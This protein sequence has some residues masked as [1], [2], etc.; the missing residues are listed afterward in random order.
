M[1]EIIV[2]TAC[3]KPQ[4]VSRCVEAM[5]KNTSRKDY[6]ISVI[7]DG[8]PNDGTAEWCKKDGKVDYVEVNYHSCTKTRNHGIRRVNADYYVLADDDGYVKTVGWLGKMVE[9]AES[10]PNVLL[11]GVDVVN[12]SAGTSEGFTP[13][14]LRGAPFFGE[15]RQDNRG[16]WGDRTIE[17]SHVSS[18][19]WL[20]K[21]KCLNIVGYL[22]EEFVGSCQTHDLVYT[23]RI[24]KAGPEPY[25]YKVLYCGKVKV[26]HP[27]AH[28]DTMVPENMKLYDD[29]LHG[30]LLSS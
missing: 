14:D 19:L 3:N 2:S 18:T 25:T 21:R 12:E 4:W 16:E 26:V 24:N 20:L 28:R 11:V 17:V 1:I 7:N 27:I 22:N 5:R 23:M 8:S 13:M 6:H 30:R 29:F 9:A 10:H 15:H